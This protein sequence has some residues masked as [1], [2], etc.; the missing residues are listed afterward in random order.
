MSKP[1]TA[2][3]QARQAWNTNAQF[4]DER[5]AHGNDFF[6]SLVWPSVVEL[7]RPQPGESLLDIGCGNGVASH[8]LAQAGAHVVAVDFSE[9]MVRVAKERH[10]SHHVEYRVVDATDIDALRALGRERFDG[11]LCNMALMDMADIGPL[12]TA[13]ASL[14]QPKGRFVFSVMHPCFNNPATVQMGELEDCQGV[15]RTTYSVKISRYLTPFTQAGLA[16]HGQPVPHPYFHRPLEGLLGAAFEAGFVLD[17]LAERS[18]PPG[19][20]GGSTP[21]SWNGRFS[22][23]PPVMVGRLRPFAGERGRI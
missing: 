12:M 21:L 18:F 14:L 7:L 17:A 8:R 16:M 6:K 10:G 4:W 2:N 20:S 23:I 22:E 11:A 5:M 19:N 3:I 15:I 1:P 9:E 13:L